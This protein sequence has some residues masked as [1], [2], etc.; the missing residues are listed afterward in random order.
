MSTFNF[1]AQVYI[2]ADNVP[3][4]QPGKIFDRTD[5]EGH[6]Y[7]PEGSAGVYGRVLVAGASST[8]AAG[9]FNVGEMY[10]TK[11]DTCSLPDVDGAHL[12]DDNGT[13]Y[14][15]AGKAL[16]LDANGDP[17]ILGV[18]MLTECG[19]K[20]ACMGK[21]EQPIGLNDPY[22]QLE[23]HGQVGVATAGNIW[24]YCETDIIKGDDLFYRVKVTSTTD[25]VQLLGAFRNDD[26]GGNALP[27]KHGSCFQPG[28]AG[29]LFVLNLNLHN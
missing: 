24:A 17:I 13:D 26:D 28:P 11:N 21:L 6:S 25:G 23:K 1:S 9:G 12:L 5:N 22:F 18:G 20:H 19:V 3:A 27:F 4:I 2:D 8:P 14:A 16:P 10:Y 7:V 15:T 29:G